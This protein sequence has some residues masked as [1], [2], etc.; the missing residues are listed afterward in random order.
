M[1]SCNCRVLEP[2]YRG[3][4]C[5]FSC[6]LQTPGHLA[7]LIRIRV[8]TTVLLYHFLMYC[9]RAPAGNKSLAQSAPIFATI[10]TIYISDIRN[11]ALS[12]LPRALVRHGPAMCSDQPVLLERGAKGSTPVYSPII[13]NGVN[14]S[15]AFCTTEITLR[16][17]SRLKMY[18]FGAACISWSRATVVVGYVLQVRRRAGLAAEAVSERGRG[19]EMSSAF[20]SSGCVM[21]SR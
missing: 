6:G 14:F 2:V 12:P 19:G 3:G 11:T 21:E 9:T 4:F 17:A 7:P 5:C 8:L 20:L 16:L 10:A 1:R 15:S 13:R 18:L